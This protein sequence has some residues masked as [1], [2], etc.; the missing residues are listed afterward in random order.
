MIFHKPIKN[1]ELIIPAK[2]NKNPPPPG[3]QLGFC[4]E[5]I[6]TSTTENI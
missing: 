1:I 4:Q 2:V 6:I 3:N 5:N